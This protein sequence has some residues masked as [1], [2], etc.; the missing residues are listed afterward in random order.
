MQGVELR[1]NLVC[2][3]CQQRGVAAGDANRRTSGLT[4]KGGRLG[5][6]TYRYPLAVF[7]STPQTSTCFASSIAV[8]LSSRHDDL[9]CDDG[10]PAAEGAPAGQD[11]TQQGFIAIK[12]GG[13]DKVQSS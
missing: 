13:K 4:G 2:G 6:A 1:F 8:A 12:M 7:S 11:I 10:V 9:H 3:S 5:F